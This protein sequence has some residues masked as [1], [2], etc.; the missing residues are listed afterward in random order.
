L[1][2]WGNW[3]TQMEDPVLLNLDDLGTQE[4]LTKKVFDSIIGP[5]FCIFLMEDGTVYTMGKSSIGLLG[6]GFGKKSTFNSAA[7]IRFPSNERIVEIKLGKSHCL[8]RTQDGKVY[9]WGS[10]FN[11]QVGAIFD[12]D[13]IKAMRVLHK[14]SAKQS[15]SAQQLKFDESIV[16]EPQ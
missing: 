3:K 1:V 4:P 12:E 8:A 15:K 11:G 2:I 6:I 16:W 10:N 5:D 13:A 9:G 7:Q 14:N